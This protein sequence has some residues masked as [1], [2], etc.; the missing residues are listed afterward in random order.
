MR[1]AGI[2]V[3]VV[4]C[5]YVGLVAAA[6]FAELGNEVTS[7]D[8]DENKIAALKRGDPLIHEDYLPELIRR[9]H[10]KGLQFSCNLQDAVRQ[11]QVIVIAVGTPADSSGEADLSF[12]ETATREIARAVNGHKVIVE[13]STVPVHTNAWI[14]RAMV[15]NGCSV[16]DF[17]VVS[18]PE[19]L[20]EGTAVTDFLYPDR[21]I[22]GCRSEHAAGIMKELYAPLLDGSYGRQPEAVPAP[23]GAMAKPL[24][25]KTS[26]ETSE[27]IKHASNAFLAMKISFINA[28]SVVAESAGADIEDVRIGMGSDKRIGAGFLH[29][30]IGYGGS[31]FPKDISAFRAIAQSCGC[32][33]TLLDEVQRINQEQL[34]RFIAKVRK[35]LWTIKGKR[36]AALG[37]AFK[38]GTDD[39]RESPAINV[40]QELLSRDC[41]VTAFD[42][43]A[44]ERTRAV[45]GE[46]ITYA[47]DAY[48]A[49]KDADALLILTEWKE[50]ASLDLAQ[51]KRL[52]KYPIVL[53]GR[54]LYTPTEMAAAGLNYYSIGR[55]PLEL[56]QP[57]PG[58]AKIAKMS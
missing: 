29:A 1:E 54:N 56:S 4:G 17:A 41:Q 13:K 19:F 48:S 43:A 22:V 39:I 51:V 50:F 38:S 53:D 35:T 49:M 31:C 57:M 27:L 45:L 28:V 14:Q 36:L 8:N 42:P 7:V 44:M 34:N 12:V 55:P 52:L 58:R 15:F 46:K 37:L 6:C 23:D 24:Y 3:A 20:R 9:H 21:I 10:G 47:P 5:G 2:R 26:P 30:G 40:I 16:S 32:D 25:I 33:F 11:S 18:N